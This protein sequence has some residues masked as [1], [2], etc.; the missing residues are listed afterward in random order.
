MPAAEKSLNDGT[1]LVFIHTYEDLKFLLH[2]VE[3]KE[4]D[5]RFKSNH[6]C[7]EKNRNPES[8]HTIMENK[9]SISLKAMG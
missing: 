7:S 9:V 3:G 6:P 1:T 8:I 2:K 5:A 4:K